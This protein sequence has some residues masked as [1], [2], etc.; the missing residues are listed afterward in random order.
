[1]SE[2]PAKKTKK[3]KNSSPKKDNNTNNIPHEKE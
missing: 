2:I 1:M 3:N